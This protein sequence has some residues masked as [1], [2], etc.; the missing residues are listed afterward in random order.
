M[1][2]FYSSEM[3]LCSLITL[4]VI[5]IF[6]EIY[7]HQYK[8]KLLKRVESDLENYLHLM[9]SFVFSII[10]IFVSAFSFS[11]LWA[12]FLLGLFIFDVFVSI[13]DIL[14]EKRSRKNI[15]GLSTGEYLTHMLLSFHLGVMYLNLIPRLIQN[16]SKKTEINLETLGVLNSTVLVL[17]VLTFI[18]SAFQFFYLLKKRNVLYNDEKNRGFN[19]Q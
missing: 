1:D 17:G 10:F 7:F 3:I 5:A 12:I 6:D 14:V 8:T 19:G 4:G 16:V 18:Y 11:G 2:F 9:R 13:G 15:G